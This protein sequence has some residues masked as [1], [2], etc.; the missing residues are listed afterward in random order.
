MWKLEGKVFFWTGDNFKFREGK[1]LGSG[2][3]KVFTRSSKK[4]KNEYYFRCNKTRYCQYIRV[5]HS[6]GKGLDNCMSPSQDL[7][8]T[9]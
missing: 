9:L 7:V 1:V 2:E 4:Y 5:K 6:R 3:R 8:P